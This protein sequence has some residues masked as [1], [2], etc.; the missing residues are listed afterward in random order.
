M[1]EKTRSQ[2]LKRLVAVQRHLEQMA[3]Y[4]L[5]E[6]SRQRAEVNNQIDN[7]VLALGSMDPVHHAFSQSYADRF[8][9]LGIKDKQLNGMQEVHEMRVRQERAKGDRLEDNMREAVDGE[10]R[11]SDDNAVYDLIDQKFGTPASS[12]LQ[13]S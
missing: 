2:K 4:D 8:N 11:E 7:V 1:A 10:R 6:T 12:K 13:K 3:E 5:A 9:R